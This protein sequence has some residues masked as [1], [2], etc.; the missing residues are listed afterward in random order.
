V[1]VSF[2]KAFRE[3]SAL[4]FSAHYPHNIRSELILHGFR[5]VEIDMALRVEHFGEVCIL[6]SES[7]EIDIFVVVGGAKVQSHSVVGG[8]MNGG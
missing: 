2:Q 6:E 7:R 1:E 3:L 4:Y 5:V 8:R